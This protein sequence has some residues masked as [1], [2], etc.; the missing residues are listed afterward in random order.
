MLPVSGLRVIRPESGIS[1]S[2]RCVHR[3]TWFRM[4]SESRIYIRALRFA[5]G[6]LV[7]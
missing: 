7:N 6:A 5:R 3:E 1:S 2:R 4:A